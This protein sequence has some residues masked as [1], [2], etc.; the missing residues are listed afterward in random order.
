VAARNRVRSARREASGEGL[1]KAL[2][3]RRLEGKR[4]GRGATRE[5]RPLHTR[6][7]AARVARALL[8]I[9]QAP[10]RASTRALFTRPANAR[11]SCPRRK[12]AGALQCESKP[13]ICV[14]SWANLIP[15]V[16]LLASCTRTTPASQAHSIYS[17]RWK[18]LASEGDV[19]IGG[20]CCCEGTV[21]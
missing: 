13:F 10:H 3:Q 21:Q 9:E 6:T 7:T 14:D 18:E 2:R 20:N 17:T 1:T 5:A 12:Q 15:G 4:V 8:C 16:V 11:S 19:D